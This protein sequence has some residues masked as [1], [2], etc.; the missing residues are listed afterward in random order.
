MQRFHTVMAVFTPMA[1]TLA[2]LPRAQFR[3]CMH[4]QLAQKK[5]LRTLLGLLFLN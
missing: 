3:Q 5:L 2:V 1:S 4:C